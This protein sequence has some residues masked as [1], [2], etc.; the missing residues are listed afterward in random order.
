MRKINFLMIAFA[1]LMISSVSMAQVDPSEPVIEIPGGAE[2]IGQLENIIN[3]DV[4]EDGVTRLNPNRIYR[5]AADQVYI[6]QAAITFDDT[7]ATLRI[8]GADGGN[9][10]IV[11]MSP[12]EGNDPFTNTCG[13]NL[14]ITNVFWP[15]MALNEDGRTLFNFTGKTM[16]LELDKFVTEN[17][18]R[19]VFG[20]RNVTGYANIYIKNSYFRDLSQ[21]SNSWNYVIFA[22]GNNG[23]P[24]DTLWIENTSISNGGMP[25]FGKGTVTEFMYLN[26][27]TF[28]NSTK[29]PIWMERYK[30]AYFA[31][32]LFLN[33]NWEGECQ[34]TWETQIGEDFDPAGQIRF[35]TV[36]ADFWASTPG[37]VASAPAP[38][39]V[40]ILVSN[41]LN[42]FSPLLDPYYN[43]EYNDVFDKPL[44]NRPWS[45]AVGD[46]GIPIPVSNLP[47]PLL[48]TRELQLIADYDGIKEDNNHDMTMDPMVVTQSPAD[49][50][51]ADQFAKF[52]RNNYQA[53]SEDTPEEYDRT[54]IWFG[55]GLANTIP[56]GGTE[57]GNGF[58]DVTGLPEDFSY[59]AD[60]T[61][62]ID[63]LP[64]GDLSWYP[65]HI[66]AW[67]SEAQFARVMEYYETGQGVGF[68]N[69]QLSK[70]ASVAIY[71]NPVENILKIDSE[72]A[73]DVAR[74]FDVT[75]KMLF[76][77]N[78]SGVMT[79]DMDVSELN[80][81]MY[82]IQVEDVDGHTNALK[83]LK[84]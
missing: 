68:E 33:A 48:A 69:R 79:K 55:D 22:R 13:G 38:E 58:P 32:N 25:L 31:N 35:D 43:G 26:H 14:A 81:G 17:A 4:Q 20:M 24:F 84:Q 44:S 29:Y 34:S 80:N 60:I 2:N 71:P 23:E 30:E 50:T 82:I 45:P 83:F 39:D 16:R 5:L 6:Q 65:E 10:P 62:T 7:L 27:V 57:E 46:E 12:L 61:S 66:A 42:W 37:G 9:M 75:G 54:Q 28:Y 73:L 67:D 36:E 18:R 51:A 47:V 63:G 21:L 49:A 72:V 19:D 52:A 70:D 3:N 76:E 40:K 11:L 15:A 41:N 74:V 56:G 77:T 1:A 8:E 59:T 78:L 64:L 53:V